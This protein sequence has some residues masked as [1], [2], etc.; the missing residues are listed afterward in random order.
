[1]SHPGAQDDTAALQSGSSVYGE[2]FC[3]SCHAMQNAAGLM[4]GG[5]VGPELTRVG[6]RV[7]P[8]WLADWLRNPSAYEA[9]TAMPHYRFDEKDIGLAMGFLGS[10]TDPDFL[11]GA[12]LGAATPVQIAHGNA[13][14]NERGC[15][16]CHEINGIAHADNSTP[17][18]TAVGSLPLGKIVFAPG[19]A[20]TLPV[21]S[22][23][24]SASQIRCGCDPELHQPG[25]GILVSRSASPRSPQP[26]CK[27]S[28]QDSYPISLEIPPLR[29]KAVNQTLSYLNGP[30]EAKDTER[31]RRLLGPIQAEQ[32][33]NDSRETKQQEMKKEVAGRSPNGC[34]QPQRLEGQ[35]DKKHDP[36]RACQA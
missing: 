34:M 10:R 7:K 32:Q 2:A 5:D 30:R 27:E 33:R 28:D 1:M 16:A 4:V 9:D 14:I 20:H 21:T 13:L 19:I 36:G 23:P 6:S 22:L 11:S 17:E 12:H 15:A 31:S 8:E 24:K 26:Y 29:P 25:S 18:L 3:A 35:Y